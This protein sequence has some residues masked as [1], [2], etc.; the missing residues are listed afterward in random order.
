MTIDGRKRTSA[1]IAAPMLLILGFAWPSPAQ[2][3]G[4]PA[5]D[6]EEPWR[7]CAREI[8]HAER[9]RRIPDLL[10]KAIA[11]VESGRW[12]EEAQ[13]ILAWP[14][15]VMAEG[16]G[17]YLPTKAAAIAEVRTLRARG[18]RNIDVGCM[19]VNLG[20][21]GHA[22]ASLQRALDPATNVAYGAGFLRS[23]HAET[24]SWALATAHYHNRDPARGESYRAKVY[25]LWHR[26]SPAV[27]E[28]ETV[29]IAGRD[30]PAEDAQ[31]PRVL[32]FGSNRS[33]SQ[34]SKGAPL[35][36]RGR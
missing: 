13:A 22:F 29:Q 6:L 8:D 20:H 27:A 34:G 23:L 14:W 24:S 3:T 31:G 2:A 35:V 11:Q 26:L 19:Q 5:V 32:Q 30:E 21:H 15:T 18:V 17:R 9:I 1:G 36:L 4:T 25:R 16:R 12:N 28:A 10:L 33:P 7:L